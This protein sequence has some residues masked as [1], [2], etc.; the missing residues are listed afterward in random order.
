[1]NFLS[2]L[3]PHLIVC[4][5]NGSPPASLPV[6]SSIRPSLPGLNPPGPLRAPGLCSCIAPAKL[7]RRMQPSAPALA[8]RER[9]GSGR[10]TQAP[11][12]LCAYIQAG[13]SAAKDEVGMDGRRHCHGGIGGQAVGQLLLS[14]MDESGTCACSRLELLHESL[15]KHPHA[16]DSCLCF[17]QH[18][19]FDI[20][21]MAPALLSSGSPASHTQAK[22]LDRSVKLVHDRAIQDCAG[23][24][25]TPRK[26][27]CA[28]LALSQHGWK[29]AA[30]G[31]FDNN[32]PV[33]PLFNLTCITASCCPLLASHSLHVQSSPAVSAMR[34]CMDTSHTRAVWP[35]RVVAGGT[36]WGM[37]AGACTVRCHLHE[38]GHRHYAYGSSRQVRC[39]G[40]EA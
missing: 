17:V 9:Q 35:Q 27:G 32:D 12:P 33:Q 38:Q 8:R 16:W 5:M 7:W 25:C 31:P 6:A 14:M 40:Q 28:A 20:T 11:R 1:M 24:L 2:G 39:D 21:C 34:P 10:H 4:M 37:P 26:A 30:R 13:T 22:Q 23:S 29:L 19:H 3:H 36:A 15:S 18:G